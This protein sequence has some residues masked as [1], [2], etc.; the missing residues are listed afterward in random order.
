M[1]KIELLNHTFNHFSIIF[2][3]D[4]AFDVNRYTENPA[5][6]RSGVESF[7]ETRC[8]K[9]Q[10]PE[11]KIRMVNPK[12]HKERNRRNCTVGNRNP[13]GICWWKHFNRAFGKPRA[14]KS[15]H[16]Q[17]H[18]VN[19]QR[20]REQNWNPVLVSTVFLRT[21]R[22]NPDFICL[23]T[24]TTKVSCR[25]RA[26]AFVPELLQI[27]NFRWRKWIRCAVVVQ[28]LATQLLQSYPYETKS[29]HKTQKNFVEHLELTRKPEIIY[30]DN[31]LE[32]GKSCE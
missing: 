25:R 14:R 21:F 8:M 13:V 22:K 11:T 18:L 29:S 16:F 3:T 20:S 28:D 24:E 1:P 12:K 32:F 6:E 7:G 10:K 23:K 19:F 17:S 5:P 9:P 2:I 4:A 30:T 27:T 26:G 31:R 15:R